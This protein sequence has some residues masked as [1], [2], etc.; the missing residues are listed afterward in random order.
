ML[1]KIILTLSFLTLLTA[2]CQA[3]LIEVSPPYQ[4][5][6][7]GH[8]FDV[9]IYCIPSQPVKSFE[10][11]ISFDPSLLQANSVSPG[12][13]F[14]GHPTF[15]SAGTINN[16]AGKIIDIYDLIIGQGNIS[17]PGSLLIVNFTGNSLTGVSSIHIYNDGLTNETQYLDHETNDGDIQF[18][19]FYP[20]DVNHDSTIDYLDCSLT[21][22]HYRETVTP[23]GSQPWDIVIDGTVNYLD[24]SVLVSHYR[25]TYP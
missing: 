6:H 4:F 11:R 12:T 13:F 7:T 14:N 3:N 9:V 23:P 18:Y 16:T 22:G 17:T 8:S 24:L 1:Q 10:M 2:S 5:Q 25:E 15:F 21:I 20:W 19:T